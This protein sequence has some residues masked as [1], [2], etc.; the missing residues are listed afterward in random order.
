MKTLAFYNVK[1]G[2]GKTTSCVNIAYICAQEG[3]RTLVWDLD[4]QGGATFYLGETVSR[5]KKLKKIIKDRKQFETLIRSSPYPN[6]D[7]IPA[8][9]NLRYMDIL[10]ED[11][12]KSDKR[13]TKLTKKLQDRYEFMIL[14]CPPSISTLSESIFHAVDLIVMPIIPTTLSMQ[15]LEQ[16]RDYLGE[17]EGPLPSMACFFSMVDLRKNMHKGYVENRPADGVFLESFIPYRSSIEKMGMERAPLPFFDPKS[18]EA[19]QYKKLWQE[20]K[21][22]IGPGG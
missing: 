18:R 9:F 11:D 3:H 8:D 6:L 20:L 17:Q 16:V 13:L 4:A 14:D 15:S 5:H 19:G 7:L 22:R 12:K 2:V 10:L 21:K 1:G